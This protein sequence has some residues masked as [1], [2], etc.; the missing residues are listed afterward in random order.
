M[1]SRLMVFSAR[2]WMYVAR[3]SRW[4]V[5]QL[6]SSPKNPSYPT[7]SLNF[8][9]ADSASKPPRF[10]FVIVGAGIAGLCAAIALAR[11]GHLVWILEQA[12]ALGEVG[13]L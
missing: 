2:L 13:E 6:T 9:H 1:A 12:P 3:P 8:L 4:I 5:A 10:N 11:Q 7:N